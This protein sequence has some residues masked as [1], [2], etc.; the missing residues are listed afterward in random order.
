LAK[1]TSTCASQELQLYEPCLNG[2][3]C[4]DHGMILGSII[5]PSFGQNKIWKA[6]HA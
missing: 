6:N 4:K 2:A 1:Y 3:P 5:F